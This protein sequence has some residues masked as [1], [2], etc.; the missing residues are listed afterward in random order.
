MRRLG[1]LGGILAVCACAIAGT[2]DATDE[3]PPAAEPGTP[4]APAPAI[5][6]TTRLHDQLGSAAGLSA[7]PSAVGARGSLPAP[8]IMPSFAPLGLPLPLPFAAPPRSVRR[9]GAGH[10]G[11]P[12]SGDQ[13]SVVD[14]PE[15][16]INADPQD[17]A[18]LWMQ[19]YITPWSDDQFP[20]NY[21][22]WRTKVQNTAFFKK[23]DYEYRA[24]FVPG[25]GSLR[26][27]VRPPRAIPPSNMLRM[28]SPGITGASGL[29]N[30]GL[31][32][33]LIW[34]ILCHLDP[35]G[36]CSPDTYQ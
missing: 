34:G 4:L 6:A 19:P 13:D 14:A 17:N 5:P 15:T 29:P 9:R 8:P 27:F 2:G 31:V 30:L 23:P 12:D 16:D 24:Q 33:L 35:G 20:K 3:P 32:G 1:G 21:N 36:F 18:Q 7:R 25:V 10:G 26:P 22:A 28:L 11:R